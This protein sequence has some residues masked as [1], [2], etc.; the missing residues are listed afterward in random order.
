M[1]RDDA[2]LGQYTAETERYEPNLSFHYAAELRSWFSRLDFDFDVIKPNYGDRRPDIIIH[3]RQH[4]VLNFL[5]VEVKR[6][7]DVAGANDDLVKIQDHW[8]VG[9]LR[10]RFGA[11]VVLGE[12][13]GS[14]SV[15]L[16]EEGVGALPLI[17]S[18]KVEFQALTPPRYNRIRKRTLRMIADRVPALWAPFPRG[19]WTPWRRNTSRDGKKPRTG[20]KNDLQIYETGRK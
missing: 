17:I 15:R 4:H 13:H 3:R 10:Y 8:F 9:N 11:S 2:T 14:F 7:N 6:G 12:E 19:N 5:V 16:L 1:W 18:S 20:L